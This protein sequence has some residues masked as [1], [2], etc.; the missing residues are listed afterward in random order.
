MACKTAST[1]SVKRRTGTRQSLL[2][3]CETQKAPS[4]FQ[5]G[6]FSN[7]GCGGV[8]PSLLATA[9]SASSHAATDGNS[10][11]W[12]GIS[13]SR[14]GNGPSPANIS[15]ALYY[16]YT[17]NNLTSLG[18]L[19]ELVRFDSASHRWRASF[20]VTTAADHGGEISAADRQRI[21][22]L[23]E[24]RKI[25]TVAEHPPPLAPGDLFKDTHLLEI[26]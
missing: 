2:L 13:H 11:P 16:A 18:F 12:R 26:G 3:F 7:A 25:P 19:G 4:G 20:E 10:D 1:V 23:A 24:D 17:R 9:L 6:L 8:Q 22:P 14:V 5:R 21:G 15:H